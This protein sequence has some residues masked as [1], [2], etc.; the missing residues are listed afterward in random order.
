MLV[1]CSGGDAVLAPALCSYDDSGE[2]GDGMAAPMPDV[3]RAAASNIATATAAAAAAARGTSRKTGSARSS[4]WSELDQEH[5]SISDGDGGAATASAAA[6]AASTP[7]FDT[8][9]AIMR[10]LQQVA[11]RAAHQLP[12]GR[13]AAAAASRAVSSS[14][15][16]AAAAAAAAFAP[17]RRLDGSSSSDDEACGDGAAAAAVP[18]TEDSSNG[19]LIAARRAALSAAAAGRPA[20]AVAVA[21]AQQ[22][23]QQAAAAAAAAA[24]AAVPRVSQRPA[25]VPPP[26]PGEPECSWIVADSD[27]G[28]LRVVVLSAPSA[29]CDAVAGGRA[30]RELATFERYSLGARLHRRLVAEAGALYSRLLPLLQE[31]LTEAGPAGRVMLAGEGL[32]GSLAAVLLLM[33]VSR[34]MR[35]AAFAPTYTLD[36]PAVLAETPDVAA[37]CGGEQQKSCSLEDLESLMQDVLTRGLLAQ[38]G[39][40]PD[41]VR[42]VY[43]SLSAAEGAVKAVSPEQGTSSSISAPG[44]LP[45]AL[46]AWLGA[47][48]ADDAEGAAESGAAAVK[49]QG[50]HVLNPVGRM[51]LYPAAAAAAVASNGARSQ[52]L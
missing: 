25:L 1:A 52:L 3:P 9:Q 7:S 16:A 46:R 30:A 12:A 21:A 50:F 47:T 26:P 24:T 2:T 17:S 18:P 35:P 6:A 36:A 11:S 34:G 40:R 39:M 8:A 19:A 43:R 13:V 5:A 27:D 37:V 29:L 4:G 31:Y 32:G 44:R 28:A 14:A 42:N 33:C 20:A 10:Q 41:A 38:L 51:L 48:R 22:A 49:H 23:A 45:D 15:A